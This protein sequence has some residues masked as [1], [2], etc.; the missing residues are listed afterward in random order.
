MPMPTFSSVSI[1]GLL[2]FRDEVEKKAIVAK[3]RPEQETKR[4]F[5]FIIRLPDGTQIVVDPPDRY[6]AIK[7]K[8]ADGAFQSLEYLKAVNQGA[9]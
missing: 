2:K 1:D 7:I 8:F 9:D 3:L 6:A 5:D 4:L